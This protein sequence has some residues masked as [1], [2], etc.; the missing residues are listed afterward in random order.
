MKKKFGKKVKFTEIKEKKRWLIKDLFSSKIDDFS[1]SLVDN[2]FD[3][4]EEKSSWI[5]FK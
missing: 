5:K 1:D 4:I 3:K 2:I